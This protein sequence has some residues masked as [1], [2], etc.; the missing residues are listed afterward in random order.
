MRLSKYPS[1]LTADIALP[2]LLLY[3]ALSLFY[4]GA[5]TQAFADNLAEL[6]DPDTPLSS[7]ALRVNDALREVE[8]RHEDLAHR[9]EPDFI[10][11]SRGIIGRAGDD[12]QA[13]ENNQPGKPQN[14]LQSGQAQF[15]SFPKSALLGPKSPSTPGLP[16][17]I[18]RRDEDGQAQGTLD[19]LKKR[20]TAPQLFITLN[21]CSQPLPN[22]GTSGTAGQL[23][24]FISTSSSNQKPSQSNYNYVMSVDG[25]YGSQNIA[26]S[27]D[28]FFSV[29]APTNNGFTGNYEYELTASIDEYYAM[30]QN[31]NYSRVADTDTHNVL[32][33]TNDLTSTNS[34][35]A[36][37]QEWLNTRAFSVYI[38]SQ[39]NPQILGI[40]KSLCALNAHN[41]R[42][43]NPQS[44]D[45]SMTTAIDGQPKQQFFAQNLNGSSSYNATIVIEGNSTN[46]GGGVV[47]GGGTVWPSVNF[48]T[49]AGKS[50]RPLSTLAC[51]DAYQTT[52]APS[53][54]TSHSAATSAM[55]SLG[56]LRIRI[57]VFRTLRH[58]G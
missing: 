48:T 23:Q 17:T 32:L 34:S 12:T 14:G 4:L 50:S 15:Y 39:Q 19:E 31:L 30:Y 43:L 33:Y 21:T 26:A 11:V 56:T 28:V 37:F 41:Q 10:G 25:G 24:L 36:V 2:P 47:N 18:A 51:T 16:S 22:S 20:Q 8:P 49:K 6:S 5:R 44:N 3:F 35:T 57:L 7:D 42:Y 53:F 52:I 55:L 54:T 1:A 58:W 27:D 38:Y 40:Q 29:S 45:T 46:S 13:L 9:Y